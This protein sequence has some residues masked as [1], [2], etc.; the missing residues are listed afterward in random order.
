M[1]S[2][3]NLKLMKKAKISNIKANS[4]LMQRLNDLGL[5]EGIDIICLGQS[6]LNDPRA[7]LIGGAVVA[8]RNEDC[9]LIYVQ[10]YQSTYEK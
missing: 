9:E 6:P 8:L 5:C 2:L 1:I 3:N 4:T 7:Y 10:P